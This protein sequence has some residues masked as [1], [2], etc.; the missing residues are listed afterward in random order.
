[1]TETLYG[2]KIVQR[3]FAIELANFKD[4]RVFSRKL[5]FTSANKLKKYL[6]DEVPFAVYNGAIFEED[7]IKIHDKEKR[8]EVKVLEADLQFD[9]D[10]D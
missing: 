10:A 4:R 8:K 2:S 6:S 7:L 3:E 9:I 1:M 5:A